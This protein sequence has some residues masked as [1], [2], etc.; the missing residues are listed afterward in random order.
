VQTTPENQYGHAGQYMQ[1]VNTDQHEIEHEKA[2][3]VDG[4]S[5]A[6]LFAVFHGLANYKTW[7]ACLCKPKPSA[8][9]LI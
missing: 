9:G 7:C 4:D 6:Y 2:I 8:A 3:R 5:S 1:Q